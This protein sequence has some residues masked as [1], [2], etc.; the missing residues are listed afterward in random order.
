M[1]ISVVVPFYTELSL[2]GRAV[3]S[4]FSQTGLADDVSF[5]I[6]IGNDGSIANQDVLDAIGEGHRARVSIETNR[7]G[8]GPGGARNT[9]I[10]QSRGDIIAF[11]DADDQWLPEKTA[12]QLAAFAG[13]SSFVAGAYRFDDSET[14][15]VPPQ[16]LDG[17]LDVFWRQGIGTSTAM[18]RRDLVGDTRFR[19]FR[20]SQD[21]DFWYRI[22]KKPGFVYEGVAQ[23]VAIYST[24]GST[25]NKLVQAKSFWTVL[26][27]NQVP[28][29][30]SV[31][32]L[33]RY[34][35]R[36]IFNHYLS[37]RKRSE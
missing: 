29:H 32:V 8:K 3:D 37:P 33:S 16:R 18:M 31:A 23:P 30:L 13:G 1:L 5:Q 36:G 11:L 4:V 19:D 22:A 2:I 12:I 6:C 14:I 17:A 10:E 26:Q 24:G 7:F 25:K 21:I 34:A 15:V 20:F 28:L 9:G 27:H 35:L